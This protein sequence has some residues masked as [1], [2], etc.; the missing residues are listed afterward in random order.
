METRSRRIIIAKKRNVL[1]VV[2]DRQDGWKVTQGK[3]TITRHRTKNTAVKKGRNLAKKQ[4]PS[5]LV[6]H[7]QNGQIQTE[8]TYKDDPYPPEG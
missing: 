2:P 8:Y 3:L 5:Q 4:K 7:K 6:I 1:R